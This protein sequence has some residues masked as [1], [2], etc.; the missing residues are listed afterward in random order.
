[1]RVVYFPGGAHLLLAVCGYNLSR[2]MMPIAPTGERV[3]AGLR[4]RRHAARTHRGVDGGRHASLFG[5]YDCGRCCSSTTTSGP[6]H[7]EGDHWHFW[8]IEVFVH[9]V[10]LTT[11]LLAIP[12]VRRL[13][14]RRPYEFA[15]AV[16]AVTLVFRYGIVEIGTHTNLR[17]RTHGVAWF[18]ALGWLVHRSES[19][20][21]SERV[22]SAICVAVVPG[23]FGFPQREWFIATCLVALLWWREV[24][25]PRPAVGPIALVSAASMWILITHF[26]VWPPLTRAARARI[27]V[28]RHDRH[29]RPRV[30]RVR[31]PTT[32]GLAR[33]RAAR[34]TAAT[35]GADRHCTTTG[36]CVV[37]MT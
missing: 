30:A 12:A 1:M 35:S 10:L 5:A 18:F 37:R 6:E 27:G 3:R 11:L 36:T 17:F 22:T 16:L 7:H 13:E 28:P 2:F 29:R 33:W 21:A 19:R 4:T 34:P 20:A 31:S 32:G 15:L 8:F 25:L 26:T 9:L 24:P 23:F 14:R